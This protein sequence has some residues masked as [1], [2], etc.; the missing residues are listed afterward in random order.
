MRKSSSTSDGPTRTILPERHNW[1]PGDRHPPRR[2]TRSG[3]DD[4][5]GRN[6]RPSGT[7]EAHGTGRSDDL[8]KS[9]A[10]ALHGGIGREKKRG[11]STVS[12]PALRLDR[13]LCNRFGH[14]PGP[15]SRGGRRSD[16]YLRAMTPRQ[17]ARS[18]TVPEGAS[19]APRGPAVWCPRRTIMS[20]F[21][22]NG[23]RKSDCRD[24]SL[25]TDPDANRTIPARLPRSGAAPPG[26]IRPAPNSPNQIDPLRAGLIRPR[27][28]RLAPDR[29]DGTDPASPVPD[30]SGRTRTRTTRASDRISTAFQKCPAIAPA[31]HERKRP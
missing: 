12:F 4:H 19:R 16:I 6:P 17:R 2:A 31:P 7:H 11:I 3:S 25:I 26:T 28:G 22:N 5:T 15:A 9:V 8:S 23:C 30:R 1:E 20:R 24:E 13:S 27:P 29:V 10:K 14:R 21:D 18:H